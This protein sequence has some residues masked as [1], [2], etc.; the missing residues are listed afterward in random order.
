MKVEVEES[1]SV[2]FLEDGIVFHNFH[3]RFEKLRGGLERMKRKEE[4]KKEIIETK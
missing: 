4:T 2:I 1:N 3:V